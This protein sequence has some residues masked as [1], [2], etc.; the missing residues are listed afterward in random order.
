MFIVVVLLQTMFIV[1]VLLQTM[2][3]VVVLLYIQTIFIVVLLSNVYSY[4]IEYYRH[5]VLCS[6]GFRKNKVWD[7]TAMAQ[8]PQLLSENCTVKVNYELYSKSAL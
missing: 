3:I 6:G 5:G 7:I 8:C 1:V 2:F 4:Y